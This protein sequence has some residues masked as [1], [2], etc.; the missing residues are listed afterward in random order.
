[1][2]DEQ[3]IQFGDAGFPLDP[4][5]ALVEVFAASG[6]ASS[7]KGTRRLALRLRVLESSAENA[8][9]VSPFIDNWLSPKLVGKM[10]GLCKAAGQ[11][12]P[13]DEWYE[14][15]PPDSFNTDDPEDS[16]F[17]NW[18]AEFKGAQFLAK[19]AVEKQEGYSDKNSLKAHFPA[20][21]KTLAK[22]RTKFVKASESSGNAI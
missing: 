19:I 8:G 1:M 3:D 18:A 12:Y 17:K 22:W 11:S 5:W 4:C 20:D 16:K 13:K 14:A 15:N 21:D 2:V 9:E 7:K 6:S 10:K